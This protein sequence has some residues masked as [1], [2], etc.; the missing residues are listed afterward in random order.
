LGAYVGDEKQGVHPYK[1]DRAVVAEDRLK[2]LQYGQYGDTDRN[3]G[4]FEN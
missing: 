1:P 3:F 4:Y 2:K